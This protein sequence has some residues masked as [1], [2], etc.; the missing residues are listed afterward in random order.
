MIQENELRI[1]MHIAV[2]GFFPNFVADAFTFT[3]FY[4]SI[5]QEFV[6]EQVSTFYFFFV[7]SL[8]SYNYNT[9]W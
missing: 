8:V 7:F 6:I 1:L 9:I 2:S 5:K 3:P 4:D